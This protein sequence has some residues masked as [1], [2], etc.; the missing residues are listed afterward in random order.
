MMDHLIL[1]DQRTL[2]KQSINWIL[3]LTIYLRVQGS[4]ASWEQV[5]GG[6]G[7]RKGSRWARSREQGEG[8]RVN[9][10]GGRGQGNRDQGARSS[11]SRQQGCRGQ[12]VDLR[13]NSRP[14]PKVDIILLQGPLNTS[15]MVLYSVCSVW[16]GVIPQCWICAVRWS[17]KYY[18]EYGY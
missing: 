1:I 10:E 3:V 6:G 11:E 5:N 2:I 4:R 8:R 9:G 17:L 13:S 16:Y 18:S 15:F 14:L 12:G 7:L